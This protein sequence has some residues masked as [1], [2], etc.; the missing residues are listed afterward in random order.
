MENESPL[1][2]YTRQPKI[3]IDLPSK[4]KYYSNNVLYEDS[5][6]NLAVFSMTANDEIL[7][8]TPDA[9]INGQATA[10]NIQSCIPSILKPFSLVTLDVDALLLSI[11]LA[12]YGPKMQIGQRCR[13][14]NEENEYEV[15]ISKYIEYL[16]RLEFDDSM[17][18][19]DFK[20]NFVP[21]TY[22]DYT[23]LQKESVGYQRALSI[24]IPNIVDEDEKS[25][26]TDQ[27]L[28]SI[29]KMN[30]KSILLS[31]N[32]IEVEGEVEKDKKAIYEFIESYDVDM[33]KAIKAHIDKQYE[34][35]LLPEETVK[36]TACDAENK[37]R[38]TI[39]QT[40]FFAK[41]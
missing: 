18:Y 4:G 16:N 30:M 1:K 36:C 19:N 8:R 38:I 24:Q 7:Y 37:I 17:M 34:A 35:W 39:D 5:Y 11:R 2:K 28:S 41:G 25:K 31:I 27:I 26:A 3:Y 14:C 13:K 9:L 33:F 40:D 15:D 29:A 23:D 21:L 22:T 6:S 10:K 20:I 12:T 32:S